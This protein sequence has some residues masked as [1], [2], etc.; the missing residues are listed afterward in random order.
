[1]SLKGKDNFNQ[2]LY[3]IIINHPNKMRKSDKIN[4]SR[5]CNVI[6][7]GNVKITTK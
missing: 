7:Y 5:Y 3:A 4:I 6:F 1:M 2:R